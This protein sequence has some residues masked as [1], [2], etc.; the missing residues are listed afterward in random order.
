M[1]APPKKAGLSTRNWAESTMKG[2]GVGID[3]GENARLRPGSHEALFSGQW[4][5]LNKIQNKT[6][7][8][9]WLHA[10]GALFCGDRKIVVSSAAEPIFRPHLEPLQVATR[11]FSCLGLSV[12]CGRHKSC[13]RGKLVI[14]LGLIYFPSGC[15][16]LMPLRKQPGLLSPPSVNYP[17]LGG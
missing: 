17:P 11:C 5:P 9:L 7:T 4:P 2:R 1:K 14:N 3:D 8:S 15:S 13:F 10:Y 6:H 12:T 16:G